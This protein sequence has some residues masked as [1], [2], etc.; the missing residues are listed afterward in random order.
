M[1]QRRNMALHCGRAAAIILVGLLCGCS[2]KKAA[3]PQ[4]AQAPAPAPSPAP[5]EP[6][7]TEVSTPS[8]AADIT[9][10]GNVFWVCGVDEMIASSSDGGNTWSL[11]HQIR[12]GA[13]LLNIA[14]VNAEIGHAAGKN[15]VLLSTT[16][17][18]KT[19]QSHTIVADPRN[20]A[21]STDIQKF[22]F[23][24]AD[25][26]IAIVGA[27]DIN[28][29]S[30]QPMYY[31]SPMNAAVEL[32]HDGGKHWQEVSAFGSA[33]PPPFSRVQAVA[34][35][36]SSHYLMILNHPQIEDAFV[37]S[38]DG[39]R[40][41]KV[42][43]QRDDETN[44]D[45]AKQVFVHEGEYWAF[46]TQ[47]LN[48]QN[49]GGY[50]EAMTRHSKDGQTWLAGTSSA[51]EMGVCNLQGCYLWDGAV[52]AL[53]DTT[54]HYWNMPQD[55]SLSAKWAIAANRVCTIGTIVQ[56]A[57]AVSV[58]K[59]QPRLQYP[60]HS[61]GQ[62]F[63][64]TERPFA[65]DCATCGVKV[66]RLD[67]GTNWQGRIV[68]SFEIDQDG[69]VA[70]LSEDGAPEGP[71]GALIEGQVKRWR[72]AGQAGSATAG[73]RQRHVAIDVKCVDAPDVPTMDGC[74]L[75]PAERG[76]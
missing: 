9:A 25:N 62:P 75:L 47:L 7:W 69:A 20:L 29:S 57:P 67:P 68:V 19:W 3:A 31:A 27:R 56:C 63:K 50:M 46:G 59:P 6:V 2:S 71:L 39:G 52:E 42:I 35:L 38:A 5:T 28:R 22:S 76:Q 34:A 1:K 65:P 18:G 12:G 21:V 51:S 14:F 70:D 32:T 48:R 73:A 37:I 10:V 15:G 61:S 4:I 60:P 11:K 30:E 8:R 72:F 45:F 24:D 55:G 49:G 44:R 23:A 33:D 16:D 13:V 58:L 17:G 64:V 26:G 36:D 66:I 74:Q 53:Y 43:H 40:T 54:G 41:W